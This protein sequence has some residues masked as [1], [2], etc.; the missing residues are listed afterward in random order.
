MSRIRIDIDAGE[1]VTE[2]LNEAE[3]EDII[4][5]MHARGLFSSK[6][7]EIFEKWELIEG[8][9]NHHNVIDADKIRNFFDSLES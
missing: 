4:E 9:I 8:I 3:N 2:F 5:Q 1:Y 7:H 6:I